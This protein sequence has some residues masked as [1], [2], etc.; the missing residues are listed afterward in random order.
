MNHLGLAYAYGNGKD[1][2][3]QYMVDAVSR[4]FYGIPVNG[5][6]AFNMETIAALNDAVGGVTVTIPEMKN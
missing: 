3:C 2:S 6:A 5:Y 4:L 1:T